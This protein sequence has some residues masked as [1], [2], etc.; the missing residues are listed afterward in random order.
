MRSFTAARRS[1]K[2]EDTTS[3][4]ASGGPIRYGGRWFSEAS[5]LQGDRGSATRARRALT[6]VGAAFRGPQRVAAFV[7]V[8]LRTPSVD[9]FVSGSLAGQA[10]RAYFNQHFLGVFPKN[11]LCQGVLVLPQHRSDYLRGRR[12]HALRTNLRRAAAA[13][14]RCEVIDDGLW[15]VEAVE[16]ITRSRRRAP[17]AEAELSD[18]R[19]IFA[20]RE[21]TLLA[22]R[23]EHGRPLGVVAAV[24][25]EMVCLIEWTT[26]NSREARW[27]LHDHLV[28]VLIGR[29]VRY[30]LARGE[31]PF[32]A[33]G[34]TANVQHYQHLL[35][36][37]LRHLIQARPVR[38]TRRRRL[39]AS[40]A[41]VAATVAAIAPRAVANTGVPRPGQPD[42]AG[43]GVPSPPTPGGRPR[44]ALEVASIL[45]GPLNASDEPTG[46]ACPCGA[47]TP[48]RSTP[49]VGCPEL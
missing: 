44:Y 2:R 22:A 9:V 1:K 4:K 23:D 25:D 29:G 26:S 11:R 10:L 17:L 20:R 45:T 47:P 39:V 19:S 18:V 16:V 21:M 15:A 6:C 41:V 13:G 3:D 12:R 33:L 36:Y 14:I 27:A 5:A 31:G 37:E 28:D 49:R 43:P 32:G 38:A 35:G 42:R 34:F 7:V 40:L 46:A 30:L 8:L 48:A 24:I